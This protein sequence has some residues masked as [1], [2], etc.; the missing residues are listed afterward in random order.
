[1][2]RKIKYILISLIGIIIFSCSKETV[3]VIDFN[4][5][6]GDGVE[7]VQEERDGT[8]PNDPCMYNAENQIFHRTSEE[9]RNLD[10]DGDGV[11]NGK[12]LDPDGDGTLGPNHTNPKSICDFNIN[13]LIYSNT[14][15]I[16]RNTDCDGDGVINKNEI[17]PDGNNM[18]DN[19][20]TD[21]FD[22]CDLILSKQTIPPDP[23]WYEFDC[24]EDCQNNGEE[25]DF[26]TDPLDDSDY[27]GKGDYL[28][29]L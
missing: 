20:G 7:T 29:E 17:D 16:W 4:D 18:N 28:M 25:L 15:P 26:G 6:D 12:E 5:P 13:D 2:C 9:W 3:T 21:P 23:Y 11:S 14:S 19:N 24:D 22:W 8:N 1:M 10:C 27:F